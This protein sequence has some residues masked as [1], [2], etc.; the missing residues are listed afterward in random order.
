[1]A[2]NCPQCSQL[3]ENVLKKCIC[4]YAFY[5]ILG[6]KEDAPAQSVEETY[7][8]L[9]KVWKIPAEAHN[10]PS[11]GKLD[12]R[13]K[14][15]N[16][17]YAVF[18]QISGGTEGSI[19]NAHAIKL[20]VFGGIGLVLL[21]AISFFVFSLGQEKAQ[22]PAALP[23]SPSRQAGPAQAAQPAASQPVPRQPLSEIKS[24]APDM[25]ADKTSDWA[26]ESVKMSHAL[27]RFATVDTLVNKWTKENSDKLKMIGWLAR[28][29]D[30]TTYLVTY[31]ATDGVMPTGF[32]F[33]VNVET[34]EVRNIALN[35][36]LQQKYGI[37][38]N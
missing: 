24:D 34:G 2:W 32:Y 12:E 10:A 36:D 5:D 38:R 14:K 16:D 30:E 31:T 15:I 35:A 25:S 18:R 4:G 21:I 37:K 27:D 29:V 17:A 7:K 19:R 22:Q 1:M 9:T 26:I 33:E 6:L 23:T 8:Y 11:R 20:A 3:N 28:K 13:V